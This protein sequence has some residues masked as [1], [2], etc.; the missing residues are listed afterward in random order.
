M[1]CKTDYEFQYSPRISRIL[2]KIWFTVQGPMTL[3]SL[4]DDCIVHSD[5]LFSVRPFLWPSKMCNGD[6]TMNYFLAVN[7]NPSYRE[8]TKLFIRNPNIEF[9]ANPICIISWFSGM[10][11]FSLITSFHLNNG[12]LYKIWGK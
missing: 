9:P 4:V 2:S 3:Y 6:C 8:N 1:N 12:I 11:L 7:L 10:S 5:Y